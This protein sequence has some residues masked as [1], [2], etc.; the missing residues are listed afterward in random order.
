M[1]ERQ[2]PG[3]LR[4]WLPPEWTE[5]VANVR[6]TKAVVSGLKE[7]IS[8]IKD[9]LAGLLKR[10]EAVEAQ[11]AWVRGVLAVIGSTAGL[12]LLGLL[13]RIAKVIP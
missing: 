11:A 13:L 6:E 4:G 12:A 7:D 9:D 5:L 2:P 10:L 3:G 1:S 8:E